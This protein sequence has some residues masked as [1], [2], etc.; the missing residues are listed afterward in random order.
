MNENSTKYVPWI[1]MIKG[2]GIIAVV[3]GHVAGVRY[4]FCFHMPLFLILAGYTFHQQENTSD[5]IKKKAVRLLLPYISFFVLLSVPLILK[6]QF[7][8][9]NILSDFL[10]GGN[11]LVDTFGVFW[12]VTT[13]FAA[14]VLFNGM[15]KW[16]CGIIWYV[17][18][19]LISYSLGLAHITL[20]E[21]LHSVPMATV[22]LYFGYKLHQT[23]V[24]D[25][26]VIC[27]KMLAGGGI[28][29]MLIYPITT[30]LQIDMKSGYYGI[31]LLSLFISMWLCVTIAI[32]TKRISNIFIV[33]S[34][35]SYIGK[36]SFVIMFLHQY[37]HYTFMNYSTLLVVVMCVV[38]PVLYYYL[39]SKNSVLRFLFIGR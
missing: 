10:Y 8:E 12:F 28:L 20:P 14:L 21:G 6:G 27:K 16:K 7:F 31:P 34:V 23:D 1:D 37:I 29:A 24:M 5:F 26:N 9:S 39:C 35:L 19:A 3:I 33:K 38:I 2:I 36:A 11:R 22:Y 30:K 13:L 18:L 32:M 25:N 4:V 17:L 15:V